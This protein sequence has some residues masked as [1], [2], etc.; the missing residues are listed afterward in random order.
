VADVGVRSFCKKLYWWLRGERYLQRRVAQ[1]ERLLTEHPNF[2][3]TTALENL[4]PSPAVSVIMPTWNRAFVIGAAIRSIQ[5]QTFSDWELIVVDDGSTDSTETV[6]TSFAADPRIRYIKKPHAGQCAARNLGQREARGSLIAYLDSD[7]LWYP[8]FLAA[9]VPVFASRKDVDLVYGAKVLDSAPR[10]QFEPFDHARLI[11]EC[12]ISTSM[13]IHRRE[14]IDRFGGFDEQLSSLEDWDLVLRYT[15]HA[16]PYPLP[17]LAVRYRVMDDNRV[18]VTR[19][20]G[21]DAE[22]IRRKWSPSAK[23]N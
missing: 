18:T 21:S 20:V 8:G 10:I 9:A 5:A 11:E 7:N 17:V 12:Y 16:P 3:A 13:M 4:F 22:K 1:L 23:G 19:P 14:L 2:A 15:A 6:L